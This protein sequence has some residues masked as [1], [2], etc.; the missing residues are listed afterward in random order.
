METKYTV[1]LPNGE[2]TEHC[3]DLPEFPGYERLALIVEPLLGPGVFMEHVTVLHNG[4]YTD[5]FVDEH[6]GQKRLLRNPKATVI[7]RH[8]WMSS[9][10]GCDPEVL[11]YI[12]G[13]AVLFH[14]RVW[15]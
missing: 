12:V 8:N 6:G 10:E 2:E 5:M 14:R 13:P 15:D 7:Y 11:N 9:H 3:E 4:I 1:I